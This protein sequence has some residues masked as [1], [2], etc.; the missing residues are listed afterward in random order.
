[1]RCKVQ[2]GESMIRPIMR[3]TLFLSRKSE[4]ATAE[5]LPIAKDLRDTLAAHRNECDHLDGILI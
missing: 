5:D 3:D 1:M 4:P 2:H